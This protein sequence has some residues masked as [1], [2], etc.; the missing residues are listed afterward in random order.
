MVMDGSKGSDSCER[1]YSN[2]C[3]DRVSNRDPVE[4]G[5]RP[6]EV[7]SIDLELEA[8]PVNG[9][10]VLTVGGEVDLNTAP[11]LKERIGSLI[12]QG[13][14]RIVVDL[15]GVDF[16]DSTGLSALVSGVTR[17]GEANGELAVVCTR[18]QVLRLLSLTGL[19]HVLK[20][21]DS[22]SEAVA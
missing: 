12:E 5:R 4:V 21:H 9:W 6:T 22:V 20:V 1:R 16:M 10:M 14:H 3:S 17:T 7:R 11:Q 18:P 2:T 15:E 19:D 13:H 8:S